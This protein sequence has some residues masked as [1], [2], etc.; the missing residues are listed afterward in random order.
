VSACLI[1]GC[2]YVGTRV[3]RR[4]LARGEQVHATS[5]DPATLAPVAVRGG[6]THW[7]DT[8]DA[9]SVDALRRTA[10]ELG[11]GLRVLVSLPAPATASEVRRM[12]RALAAHPARLVLLST[13][14][15]Y[16][17]Q[18]QVDERT[19]PAPGDEA[20]RARFEME[21]IAAAGPWTTLVLRCA[22]IYGPR[23][24]IHVALRDGRLG[25]VR[26]LDRIVSRVHV[27]DLA[28]IAVAALRSDADGAWP[29]AD[30]EPAT[31][32]EVA[33]FCELL[34]LPALPAGTAPRCGGIPGRHVNGRAVRRLLSVNFQYPSYREGI[35]DAIRRESELD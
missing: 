15:V 20:G 6:V 16:G 26:D 22:A 1:L 27:E 13:T 35:S 32:R 25:R 7:L 8:S 9:R 2:G 3:A 12:F 34:G 29:V 21:R 4:L 30:D 14:S 28:S 33:A 19:A 17:A 18:L 24:G 11:P 31:T 10:A 5:R 23:R